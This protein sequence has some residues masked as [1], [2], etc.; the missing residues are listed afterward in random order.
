[1]L[2]ESAQEKFKKPNGR[3]KGRPEQCNEQLVV[4]EMAQNCLA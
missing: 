4:R 1:M 2:Q 3:I